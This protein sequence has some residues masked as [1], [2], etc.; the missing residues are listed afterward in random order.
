MKCSACGADVRNGCCTF[1]GYRPTE[2]D[3]ASER[4]WAE[5][6]ARLSGQGQ[7]RERRPAVRMSNARVRRHEGRSERPRSGRP[8]GAG[9]PVARS[10]GSMKGRRAAGSQGFAVKL[11]VRAMV[12]GWVL[13]C[14]YTFCL[15][16]K[17][18]AGV[19]LPGMFLD[20]LRTIF[21]PSGG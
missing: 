1:C 4:A 21:G 12:A 8:P 11:A 20:L 6:K 13:F 15:V 19:D 18:E 17:N 10:A 16:L 2:Q 5:E 9:Q 7:D 14:A 3:A